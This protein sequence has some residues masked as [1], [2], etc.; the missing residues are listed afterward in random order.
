MFVAP[1]PNLLDS[2]P[3]FGMADIK[4][5]RAVIEKHNARAHFDGRVADLE[6]TC[7]R[8]LR[9]RK[10]M[11]L[12][13]AGSRA[14][15]ANRILLAIAATRH[16]LNAGEAQF[17]AS[18]AVV[19]GALAGQAS[20]RHQWPSVQGWLVAQKGRRKG[21]RARTAVIQ[22]RASKRAKALREW[23]DTLRA[24]HPEWSNRSL[25]QASLRKFPQKSDSREKAINALA[26]SI[27]RL[28]ARK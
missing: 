20:A 11:Q 7:S 25:A 28:S 15:Y 12:L 23:V 24:S 3:G 1:G 13:R 8:D 17:A 4:A 9:K 2:I 14:W 6:R 26:K 18:E 27:A 5:I 22:D 21:L 10:A 16:W 19:V